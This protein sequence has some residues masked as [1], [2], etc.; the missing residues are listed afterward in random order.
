MIESDSGQ[1]D[2]RFGYGV[3]GPTETRIILIGLN[4]TA[5]I[6]GPISFE[7]FG[8][9]AT[10]FDAGGLMAVGGMILMLGR[11]VKRNLRNLAKLEP[12]NTVRD[13]D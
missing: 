11:R 9:G 7:I 12:A 13:E 4:T 8:V 1:G 5:L 2:F 3:V 10:V 6:V